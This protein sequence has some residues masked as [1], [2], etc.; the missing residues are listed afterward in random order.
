MVKSGNY[1]A[2]IIDYA[3]VTTKAGDIAPTILFEVTLP[4]G[5]G[6]ANLRWQ[7]SFK[8][9]QAAEIALGYLESCG[10]PSGDD[11][12][13]LAKGL[14]SEVLDIESRYIVKV[15]LRAGQN[16]NQMQPEIRGIY[17]SGSEGI[18]FKIND[19]EAIDDKLAS[20]N[21]SAIFASIK[22][23]RGTRDIPVV[24]AGF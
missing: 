7:G 3:L 18:Q 16:G 1:P 24:D 13:F 5:Q 21:L 6:S 15:E 20:L 10:L 22:N 23:K 17:R 4:E 8:T 2:K 19:E 14:A 9:T 11:I 12:K